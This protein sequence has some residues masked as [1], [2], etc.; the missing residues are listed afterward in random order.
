MGN[1]TSGMGKTGWNQLQIQNLNPVSG[2]FHSAFALE[3]LQQSADNL[4][5][6]TQVV[7][8]YLVSRRQEPVLGFLQKVIA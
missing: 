4:P 8:Y 5:A 3:I 2:Q 7:G 6:G 1:Y